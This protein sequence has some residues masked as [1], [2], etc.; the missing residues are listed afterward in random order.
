MRHL[1]T[2]CISALFLTGV[3]AGHANETGAKGDGLTKNQRLTGTITHSEKLDPVPEHQR[4]GR[5]FHGQAVVPG[6]WKNKKRF[7]VPEWLAG[8]W[9]RS[10]AKEIS[11]IELPSG[12]KLK[13]AGTQVAKVRDA[14]G[15][16]RDELGQIWQIFDLARAVGQIDRGNVIDFHRVHSYDLVITG[17]KSVVVEVQ[18]THT[19]VSKKD[20]KILDVYQDEELNKYTPLSDGRL[21]TDSSVK[22]FDMN[23]K[24][25][26]LTRTVSN[27]SR[28]EPKDWP[29]TANAR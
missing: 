10:E 25:F 5:I 16:Y 15:T 11:R 17:P 8:I 20:R 12:K 21:S 6:V 4:P 18:A 27:Q 19:L 23:G 2:T 24:P 13:P 9:M 3:A 22:V 1:I 26:M 14:F 7:R 29:P 28:A